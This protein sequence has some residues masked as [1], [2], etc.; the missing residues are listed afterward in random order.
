MDP[1]ITDLQMARAILHD[2]L[3]LH[4]DLLPQFGRTRRR[5]SS[6]RRRKR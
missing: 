3:E 5:A 4:G 1:M 6:E 2:Y